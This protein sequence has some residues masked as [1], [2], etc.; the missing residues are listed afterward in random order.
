MHLNIPTNNNLSEKDRKKITDL[1]RVKYYVT[2]DDWRTGRASKEQLAFAKTMY[3]ELKYD[4][5]VGTIANLFGKEGVIGDPENK[6][7]IFEQ[8]HLAMELR[9]TFR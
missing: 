6:P 2:L 1:L 4:I 9:R 8:I 5:Q 7:L 3:I